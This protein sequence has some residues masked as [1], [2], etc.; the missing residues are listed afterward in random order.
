[1]KVDLEEMTTAS[2]SVG[3]PQT[4]LE[5]ARREL[6][7]CRQRMSQMEGLFTHVADAIFVTETDGLII[8]VNP[9]ACQLLGYAKAELLGKHPWDFV[10]NAGREDI[11]DL[12]RNLERGVPTHIQRVYRTRTGELLDVDLRVTRCDLAG[13]ELVIAS[14]RNITAQKH[15]QDRLRQSEQHLAEGQRLTKTG[16][17]VL[18]YHTGN[19]DWSV[20]TCRIFGFPDPPPSPHYRE[21]R[22]RVRPEDRDAVDRGLRESFETGEPRPLKYVFILPDGTRK[23]IETISQPVRDESGKV[24][25]LMGTVMDVTEREWTEALLAGE[26]RI[27]EMLAQ[28]NPLVT[29]LEALCRLVEELSSESKAA[30]LLLAVDGKQLWHAAAPS[31]PRSYVEDMGGIEVGPEVGSCG[32][33]AHRREAVTVCDIANDPLWVKYRDRALRNGVHASW[34]TPIFA[35]GG[36]LLGTFAILSNKPC[37]PTPR[38]QQITG[39]ITHLASI[40]IE[41]THAQ[42]ATRAAEKFARGQADALTE[43]LDALVRESSADRIVEHVLRTITRQLDAHSC[44]VWRRDAASD[45]VNFELAFESGVVVTKSDPKFAG[46]ELALPMEDFWPWPEFFRAGKPS[47][48][49]DIRTTKPFALRDRLLPLGIITVL[50]VPM[51]YAGHVEGAIGLRFNQTRTFRPEELELAQALANQAMLAMQLTRLSAQS[52]QAA[53]MAERNRMARDI[54]DTLAQGF[55]GVIVQLEAAKG[56]ALRQETLEVAKRIEQADEL[57]RSSLAEARR[58]VRALRPR[59]LR[60]GTLAMALQDVLKRM[61][62]GIELNAEFHIAGE[63]RA[64]PSDWEEGLL[65]IAQESVT[66]TVKHARARNF[67]AVLTLRPDQVELQ[68]TDDGRGFDPHAEHD[69]FGLIGMKERMEQLGGQFLLRSKPEQGT[70]IIVTLTNLIPAENSTHEQA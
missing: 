44:S 52:R 64:L 31:L 69:G 10:T 15:L 18:D 23:N 37:S 68:M 62:N 70:E 41:R 40:A 42:E 28:E 38:H 39:R 17:W 59:S 2:K 8:D 25:K 20:E 27:L 56:A 9:A 22:E 47:V 45:T 11:L 16:S 66:N 19:T 4:E 61:S 34:S 29:I 48:I 51:S 5:R 67:R 35:S 57:A 43:A 54:H 50:L 32:T 6:E 53:V 58:S 30:I 65:R 7:H 26:K 13:R 49:E 36:N 63:Q 60:D 12:M 3:S 14:C 33:A 55:T 1:M 46:M 21:F 24:V